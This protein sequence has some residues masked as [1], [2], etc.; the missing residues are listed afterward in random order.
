MTLK[1]LMAT[2]PGDEEIAVGCSS[3][4]HYIG[5][6]AHFLEVE[7]RISTVLLES[8][9]TRKNRAQTELKGLCDRGVPPIKR[10]EGMSVEFYAEQVRRA[11]ERL[12]TLT[13]HIR[14]LTQSIAEFT[15]LITREVRSVE[16]TPVYGKTQI[17]LNGNEAGAFW[18]QDEY[19]NWEKTGKTALIPKETEDDESD[20]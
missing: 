5:T 1:E 20:D 18:M 14:S 2:L 3:A 19:E 6:A 12:K 9:V 7:G 16:K 4:Y 10:E 13:R 11:A 15:P 8:L 17:L